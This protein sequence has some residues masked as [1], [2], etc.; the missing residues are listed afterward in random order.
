MSDQPEW[1]KLMDLA[2]VGALAASWAGLF[3]PLAAL[4]T[5]IWMAIRI[6]ESNTVRGWTGRLPPDERGK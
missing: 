4:L 6:W 1:S 5:A 3:N 2:S